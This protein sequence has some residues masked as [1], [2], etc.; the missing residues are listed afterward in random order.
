MT[1]QR[2]IE[3]SL[4]DAGAI[5]GDANPDWVKELGLGKNNIGDAGAKALAE[6]LPYMTQLKDP[7]LN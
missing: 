6:A 4:D 2:Q 1:G 5:I 7:W 3:L